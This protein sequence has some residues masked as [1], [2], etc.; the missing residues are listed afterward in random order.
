MELIA[1]ANRERTELKSLPGMLLPFDYHD[2]L[3]KT[4]G[5]IVQTTTSGIQIPGMDVSVRPQ[6]FLGFNTPRKKHDLE[7]TNDLY[8]TQFQL[9]F[10]S[11]IFA[12][13]CLGN[14]FFLNENSVYYWDINNAFPDMKNKTFFVAKSFSAF[15]DLLGGLDIQR[16]QIKSKNSGNSI[17]GKIKKSIFGGTKK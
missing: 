3:K 14:L 2:F 4:N 17:P 10:G 6:I 16:P 9:P 13:D 12:T 11:A 8:K 15:I 7:Y 1:F 5:G